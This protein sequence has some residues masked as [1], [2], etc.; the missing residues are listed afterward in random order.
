MKYI[1]E[2]NYNNIAI[3]F[4]LF[5]YVLGFFLIFDYGQSFDVFIME[6]NAEKA[7]EFYETLDDEEFLGDAP[8]DQLYGPIVDIAVHLLQESSNDKVTDH[9]IRTA[10]YWALHASIIFPIF[11]LVRSHS[12]PLFASFSSITILLIPSIFGHA[13]MNPKDMPFAA[14]YVWTLYLSSLIHKRYSAYVLMG[15]G[16]LF[17]LLVSIRVIGVLLIPVIL[18]FIA[19][20]FKNLK[21]IVLLFSAFSL[22]S[23][24]VYIL[25]MP[26]IIARGS[27]SA[28]F[29]IIEKF[30]Q[31]NWYGSVKYFGD[32]YPSTEL[33]TFYPAFPR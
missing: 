24:V 6:R 28:F 32:F 29:E 2:S 18:I 30:R 9:Y 13:Y 17:G 12:N 4:L 33:P 25:T 1:N 22:I 21:A 5:A 27:I 7:I 10:F 31:F 3:S 23:I 15:C 11:W 8:H 26:Y 20:K 16:V 14:L 19:E